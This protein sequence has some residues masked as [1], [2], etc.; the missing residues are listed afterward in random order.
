MMKVLYIEDETDMAMIVS[1][2]LV[3]NGLDVVH[4]QRPQEAL[5]FFR[6]DAPDIVVLDVMLPDMDGFELARQFKNIKNN[7]PIIF[8]TAKTQLSDI[9]TGFGTGA[10]DYLK[11]PFMVEELVL[12]IRSLLRDKEKAQ[13]RMVGA[14]SFDHQ[15]QELKIGTEIRKMSY[16][17]S[18]ILDQLTQQMGRIVSREKLLEKSWEQSPGLSGRSLDVFISRLR[19]YLREDPCLLI[20]AVKKM[21]YRIT[22]EA[23][24]PC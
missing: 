15:R 11:K 18:V 2:S 10:N 6:E 24:D 13:V 17:E 9:A 14:F 20:T 1:E 23:H 4:Y 19:G 21:G 7:V 22:V 16:R 3:F 8:V 5:N 12:R